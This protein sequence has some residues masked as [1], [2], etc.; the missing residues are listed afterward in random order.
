MPK[1]TRL[2]LGI[3]NS[4]IQMLQS[5]IID[6]K[7]KV[8]KLGLSSFLQNLC[9]ALEYKDNK[10]LHRYSGLIIHSSISPKPHYEG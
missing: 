4:V 1:T 10:G 5:L 2:I 3:E 7:L 6:S 9:C 8:F